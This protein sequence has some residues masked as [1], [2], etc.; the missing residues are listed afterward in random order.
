MSG[1]RDEDAGLDDTTSL[2][3]R[4][5]ELFRSDAA[6]GRTSSSAVH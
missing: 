3:G 5:A 4:I 6:G 1:L 2:F